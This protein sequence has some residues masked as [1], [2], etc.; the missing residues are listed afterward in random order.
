MGSKKE[1]EGEGALDSVDPTEQERE[2]ERVGKKT[3]QV[4]K[5]VT[6]HR[7]QLQCEEFNSP[8]HNTEKN[9]D[10]VKLVPVMVEGE[11][12]GEDMMREREDGFG[13][14][15]KHHGDNLVDV[16]DEE[17]IRRASYSLPPEMALDF[18]GSPPQ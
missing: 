12:S 4:F 7:H 11:D 8:K 2:R 10:T 17:T 5:T 9:V 18:A 13:G 6:K 3:S 1:G 16:A 15:V 14:G